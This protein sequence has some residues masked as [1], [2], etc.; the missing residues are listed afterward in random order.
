MNNILPRLMLLAL[1]TVASIAT[2]VR[3]DDWTAFLGN[4]GSAASDQTVPTTWSESEN[5]VWK[6]GIAGE[7]SSSPIIVG[8]RIIVTSYLRN[9]D[10]PRRRVTCVDKN[11]GKRLWSADYPVD[12]REDA[13]RGYIMEHGYASNTPATDGENLYVFFGK[14]GVHSLTLDGEKRW[15]FDVGKQSSNRQWGSAS[16]LL[17]HDEMVIVNAAEES[18][19]MYAINKSTGKEV[20]QHAARGLE[21]TYGT[22]RLVPRPDGFD[23]VINSPEK[24]MALDPKTGLER[25]SAGTKMTGNVSPS[26]IVG[27]GVIY[28]FGG[29][30]SS[31]SMAVK[32]GGQGDVTRSNVLWSSRIS[33][34]VATPLLHEGKFYWIDDRGIAHCTRASDGGEVYRE[35]VNGLPGR[36]VYA[37]PV[38]I[39]GNIYVVTRRKGTIV[40]P[41]GDTFEP[42]AK[43]V[44]ASDNSDFNASPAVSD[45]KL[46]LRS[47]QALYCVGAAETP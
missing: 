22:P 37:S 45:G 14:G 31:G 34:Y 39:G 36:P 30:R 8:D 42:I 17:L 16:S 28:A 25:W 10:P 32:T 18:K 13:F 35:R 15:S 1:L 40:Y 44:I 6:A 19:T 33:S 26:V 47:N 3:A 24:I 4:K 41:P 46:Y 9:V 5:L 12:Y 20:W 7:G 21:L 38:L 27:D 23:L 29:Y 2:D 11:S 43:N